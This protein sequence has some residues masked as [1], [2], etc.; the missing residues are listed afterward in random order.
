MFVRI[1]HRKR[2][3][4]GAAGDDEIRQVEAGEERAGEELEPR[5]ESGDVLGPDRRRRRPR[6]EEEGDAGRRRLA[7]VDKLGAALED[8]DERG[9]GFGG[10]AGLVLAQVLADE[11]RLDSDVL[12][13]P[14]GA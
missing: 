5:A 12:C 8:V 9:V 7:V 1:A 3:Q 6:A 11:R 13:A 14:S 2:S 10:R 4:H